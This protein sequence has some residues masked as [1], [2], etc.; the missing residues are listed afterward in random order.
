MVDDATEA[1]CPDHRIGY[2]DLPPS[3][4]RVRKSRSGGMV[5]MLFGISEAVRNLVGRMAFRGF[6]RETAVASI[7]E[8]VNEEGVEEPAGNQINTPM[9]P[10]LI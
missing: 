9:P 1:H 6:E 5:P 3:E 2:V 10:P 7:V 4:S 8:V